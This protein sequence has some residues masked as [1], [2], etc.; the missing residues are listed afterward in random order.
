MFNQL[1]MYHKYKPSISGGTLFSSVKLNFSSVIL[2]QGRGEG[3]FFVCFTFIWFILKPKNYIKDCLHTGF[4]LPG[5]TAFGLSFCLSLKFFSF[6][7]LNFEAR[8]SWMDVLPPFLPSKCSTREEGSEAFLCSSLFSCLNFSKICAKKKKK[9]FTVHP[10]TKAMDSSPIGNCKGKYQMLINFQPHIIFREAR[11]QSGFFLNH[12]FFKLK[13]WAS[14][15]KGNFFHQG[16]LKPCLYH[17]IQLHVI[18]NE[19]LWIHC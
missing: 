10:P 6:K 1:L 16:F 4:P 7:N 14:I 2:C 5:T 18:K 13:E 3:F 15:E 19:L 11:N 8:V 17:Q 12:K 9:K